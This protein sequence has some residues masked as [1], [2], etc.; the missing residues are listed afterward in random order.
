MK[1]AKQSSKQYYLS[2]YRLICV[3]AIFLLFF[4]DILLLRNPV[5]DR[6]EQFLQS[7]PYIDLVISNSVILFV[8]LLTLLFVDL[9]RIRDETI[10]RNNLLIMLWISYQKLAS[11]REDN[12]S[13][14][15][16]SLVNIDNHTDNFD[17]MAV[18]D[19]A[20]DVCFPYHK[21]LL[22]YGVDGPIDE[23]HFANYLVFYNAFRE[24][25]FSITSEDQPDN[26]RMKSIEELCNKEIESLSEE[27][28]IVRTFNIQKDEQNPLE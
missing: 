1:T 20:I 14:E 21:E 6:A 2:Y 17:K 18:I 28:I 24:M 26:E 5:R 8:F 15:F 19:S 27:P 3:I 22:S 9:N 4:I 10:K 13:Y 7:M 12:P 16:L 25:I 11:M 23:D